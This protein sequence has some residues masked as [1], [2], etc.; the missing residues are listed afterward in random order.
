MPGDVIK[1]TLKHPSKKIIRGLLLYALDSNRERVGT[2]SLPS[3]DF[4]AINTVITPK[5]I[6]ILIGRNEMSRRA[7]GNNYTF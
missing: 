3:E 5:N 4:R 2:F 1:I 7:S 6:D